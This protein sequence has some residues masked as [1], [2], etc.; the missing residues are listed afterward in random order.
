M[1]HSGAGGGDD[2]GFIHPDVLAQQTPEVQAQHGLSTRCP[3]GHRQ[4]WL[5]TRWESC[6]TCARFSPIVVVRLDDGGDLS[7]RRFETEADLN[8]WQDSEEGAYKHIVVRGSN[9]KTEDR[10]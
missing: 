8:E 7:V 3:H 6:R 1:S 5:G 9:L 2:E 10:T 4:L